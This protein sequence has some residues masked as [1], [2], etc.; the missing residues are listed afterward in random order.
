MQGKFQLGTGIQG[1]MP[2]ILLWH[3]HNININQHL[4]EQFT[5]AVFKC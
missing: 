4:H 3:L 2:N 1:S 5:V